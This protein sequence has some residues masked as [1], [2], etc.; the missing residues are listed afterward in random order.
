MGKLSRGYKRSTQRLAG[1]V[2]LLAWCRVWHQAVFG[3]VNR[4]IGHPHVAD[5][6]LGGHQGVCRLVERLCSE[7]EFCFDVTDIF[8]SAG[9]VDL[10][11]DPMSL[12]VMSRMQ[13]LIYFICGEV[14]GKL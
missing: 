3:I 6:A 4:L 2:S 10:P 1:F 7:G 11:A 9:L 13:E 8:G 12:C 5:I 14:R